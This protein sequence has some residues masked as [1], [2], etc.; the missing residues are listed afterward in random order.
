MLK[1]FLS[2]AQEGITPNTWWSYDFAGHNKQATLEVKQLFDGASPF[3]TPKPV[4]L[5]RRMLE[6]FVEADG[7]VMDFFAG[8]STTAQSVLEFNREVGGDRQF[9]VVQL[10]EPTPAASVAS[11]SGFANIA[12]IGKERIRRV[13]K[14]MQAEDAD[15]LTTGRDT[16]DDLGFRVFK[17][18]RSHYKAWRDFEGGDVA[19]LQTLF[20]R[21]ES[22]LEEGWKPDN[23]LVEVMLME[24]FPLDSTT[25]AL[26]EF[27]HNTVTR[28]SSDLVAHRLFVCLSEKVHDETI[29]ALALGEEDVFICLDAALTDEA[30]VRLEDGRRVKV[31]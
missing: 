29:A 7:L 15:K 24:G 2:E 1:S 22:P 13:I 27:T 14:R 12:E 31:I 26:P 28:V 25:E 23:V 3:D 6:L 11:H 21:F 4:R 30:K 10:P 17:L 18:E 20:D 19:E 8:S 16:A 5:I 9:I